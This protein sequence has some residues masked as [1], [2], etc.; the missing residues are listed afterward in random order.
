MAVASLTK[1]IQREVEDLLHA[2]ARAID[3]DRLEAV[4]DFFTADGTYKVMSRFNQRRGLPLAQI[5]CTNRGMIADR[6]AALREANVYP[7][8][9]YRHIVSG[10]MVTPAPDGSFTVR[11]N[12]LVMRTL[13]EGPSTL[14]SSGEYLDRIVVED[15]ALRFRERVV[16]F[17]SKSI[18]TL[19]VI[20]I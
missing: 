8:H 7:S 12:Y 18:E 11:S 20:P 1:A 14:F 3:D 19:L 5:N 17:D 10:I 2:L 9:C 13:D 6:I 16:L 4:P 15:G